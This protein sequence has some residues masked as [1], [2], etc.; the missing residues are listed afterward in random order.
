MDVAIQGLDQGLGFRVCR[1]SC[2]AIQRM[3]VSHMGEK[4]E[5]QRKLAF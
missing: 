2:R 3:M 1:A 5:M 4:W